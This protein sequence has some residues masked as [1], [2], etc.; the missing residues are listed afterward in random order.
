MRRWLGVLGLLGW[1]AGAAAQ[2]PGSQARVVVLADNVTLTGVVLATPLAGI[3]GTG[4]ATRISC[5][6]T[7]SA[8]VTGTLRVYV[9]A[10]M[11]DGVTW[12]D[13]LPFNDTVGTGQ[14][15]LGANT[16]LGIPAAATSPTNL[17]APQGTAVPQAAWTMLRVSHSLI[18]GGSATYSVK[19]TVAGAS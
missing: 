2:T 16:A 9:Q 8:I 7:V 14:Q 6:R 4:N 5:L 19:C 1:A 12:T 13:F 11:D 10:S 15:Y 18:G 3:R 17:T